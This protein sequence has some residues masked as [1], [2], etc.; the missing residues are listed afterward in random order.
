MSGAVWPGEPSLAISA[1]A[2]P[3]DWAAAA[4]SELRQPP[5]RIR[6]TAPSGK[7]AKSDASQ[8]LELAAKST[9]TT[10]AVTLPPPE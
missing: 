5:R 2:A 9:G 3:A 4:L 8:P 10:C 7:P 6:A 1:A